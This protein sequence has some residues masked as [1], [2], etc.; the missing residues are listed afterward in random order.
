MSETRDGQ[1]YYDT[2]NPITEHSDVQRL[3]K[4]TVKLQAENAKLKKECDALRN[5]VNELDASLERTLRSAA[6]AKLK[7]E[8]DSLRH[9]TGMLNSMVLSGE[10]HSDASRKIVKDAMMGKKTET[11]T[12]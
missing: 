2:S 4:E 10:S 7:E 3:I 6:N 11:P 8:R 5:R 9:A 12:Q 1:R